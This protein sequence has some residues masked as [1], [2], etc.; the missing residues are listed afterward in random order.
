[1]QTTQHK[2]FSTPLNCEVNGRIVVPRTFGLHFYFKSIKIL[3][4]LSIYLSTYNKYG[5]SI[6][7]LSKANVNNSIAN[8]KPSGVLYTLA[9]IY[10]KVCPQVAKPTN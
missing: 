3:H 5:S 10:T 8:V 6:H 9:A 4:F 7:L 1:M 2:C